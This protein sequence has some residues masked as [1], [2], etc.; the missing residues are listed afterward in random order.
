MIGCAP[1]DSEDDE[2]VN[3]RDEDE[4]EEQDTSDCKLQKFTS[5]QWLDEIENRWFDERDDLVRQSFQAALNDVQEPYTFVVHVMLTAHF[6]L[7]SKRIP[8]TSHSL[9]S[10]NSISG[11]N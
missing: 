7:Y 8:I 5:Q 9:L 11:W 10:T 6:D 1:Q 4:E 2:G 3:R